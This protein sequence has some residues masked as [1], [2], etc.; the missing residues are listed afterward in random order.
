MIKL[1]CNKCKKEYEVQDY[2][3]LKSK[4]CSRVCHNSVAGK[5]GGK[6]GKGVT[7]NNGAKR[8]YLSERN[9]VIKYAG[10]KSGNWKGD[11]VGYVS[12]HVWVKRNYGKPTMCERCFSTKNIHWANKSHKYE[13]ENRNDWMQLCCS[14]HHKYD[15]TET[16]H[17]IG[18]FKNHEFNPEYA[19]LNQPIA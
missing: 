18:K 13:R 16:K 2:R 19:K 5:I 8:P 17:I 14:C 1:V 7:R 10:E 4:T 15:K 9:K 11:N 3:K 12:M 6:A